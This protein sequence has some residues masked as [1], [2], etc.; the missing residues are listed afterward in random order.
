MSD[1]ETELEYESTL[2]REDV[3]THFETFAENLRSSEGFDLEIGDETVAIAPPESLE[4]ELELEDEP[5]DD[6]V[7]R[8]IEF[9]LEWMRTDEEDPLPEP[10]V[11]EE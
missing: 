1:D 6:G 4:F 5:E 3:A 9:E 10:D 8:S 11:V 2:S 7:E